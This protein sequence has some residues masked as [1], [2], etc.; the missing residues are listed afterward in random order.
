MKNRAYLQ[1]RKKLG[2]RS[3]GA[4]VRVQ[5]EQRLSPCVRIDV[6]SSNKNTNGGVQANAAEKEKQKLC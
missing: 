3:Q 4:V 2:N 1:H 6:A 5:K